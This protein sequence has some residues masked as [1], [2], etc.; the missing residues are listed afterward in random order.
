MSLSWWEHRRAKMT[1]LA[2]GGILLLGVLVWFFFFRP[3]VS[4]DDARVAATLVRLAPEAAGGRVIRLYVQE[5]DRVKKG[6]VLVELEHRSSEANLLKAKARAD[7]LEKELK[8]FQQLAAV[9]GVPQRDLDQAQASADIAKAEYELAEIAYDRTFLKSPIDGI[10][11]Q[12][13]GEEGNILEPNQVILTLADIDHAW[14]SANIEETN[15][16]RVQKGQLVRIVVD[17]GGGLTGHISEVRA[18]T[19]AQFALIQ[20]EN[21]SGNFTKLVQRIPIKI[22]LDPHPDRLLRAGQSVEI[23]IRVW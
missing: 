2:V 19:A 21:P 7:Q 3:Y 9:K 12:K 4:T 18:A 6:A 10:V 5:G 16:A 8:R 15:V 11:V 17:E 1:G 13:A 14:V 20:A 22:E 23:R